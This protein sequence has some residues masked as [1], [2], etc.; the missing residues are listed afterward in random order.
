MAANIAM[1]MRRAGLRAVPS[2]HQRMQQVFRE[3]FDDER[4][5]I[6]DDMTPKDIPGWDSLAHVKLIIGLEEEFNCKFTVH[7]VVGIASVGDLKR[8]LS[9]KGILEL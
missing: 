7:E 1:G 6:R 8:M 9:L 2:L 5:E 4:M 3:V